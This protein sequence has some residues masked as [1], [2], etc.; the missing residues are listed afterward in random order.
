MVRA[1]STPPKTEVVELK[2]SLLKR[3]AFVCVGGTV[4]PPPGGG[5]A[6]EEDCESSSAE[7]VSVQ[8]SLVNSLLSHSSVKR[9]LGRLH[10]APWSGGLRTQTCPDMTPAI[11][12][13]SKMMKARVPKAKRPTTGRVLGTVQVYTRSAA[14]DEP[15]KL[16]ADASPLL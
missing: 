12:V 15:P 14:A 3:M 2:S 1:S 8:P 11:V 6:D 13:Y 7:L 10:A 5:A 9:T 4:S 16:G